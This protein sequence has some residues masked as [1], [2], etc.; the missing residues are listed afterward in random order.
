MPVLT[1]KSEVYPSKGSNDSDVESLGSEEEEES[2]PDERAKKRLK[3][4][5]LAEFRNADGDGPRKTLRQKFMKSFDTISRLLEGISPWLMLLGTYLLHCR[6]GVS[7]V[8][9]FQCH[10]I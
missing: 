4:D 10:V 5:P 3:H 9:G 2:E 1:K 8:I 7:R 6:G